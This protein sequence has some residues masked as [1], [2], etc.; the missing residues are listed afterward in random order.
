MKKLWLKLWTVFQNLQLTANVNVIQKHKT[1]S[2]GSLFPDDI[3]TS[4]QLTN[5]T[6]LKFN[7][8]RN[9]G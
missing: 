2:W 1:D 5:K 9:S 7:T 8:M 4:Q 3:V 6:R